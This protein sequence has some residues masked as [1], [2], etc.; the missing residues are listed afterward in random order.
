MGGSGIGTSGFGVTGGGETGGVPHGDEPCTSLSG[1]SLVAS[2]QPS[3]VA[4]LKVGDRLTLSLTEGQ[5]PVHAYTEPHELVGALVPTFLL[6]L[7]E[8]MQTGSS[9]SATVFS[10]D[11]GAVTV[12][13]Q[14]ETE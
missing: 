10:I 14:P 11:G 4:V 5:A 6:R 12:D 13:I 8:C 7:V 9:Y 1:R 3:T 2:P